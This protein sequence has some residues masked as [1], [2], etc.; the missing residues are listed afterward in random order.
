MQQSPRAVCKQLWRT[1]GLHGLSPSSPLFATAFL[2]FRADYLCLH[3]LFI[4]ALSLSRGLSLFPI[5]SFLYEKDRSL[6]CV[7]RIKVQS[8]RCG[9]AYSTSKS[10]AKNTITVAVAGTRAPRLTSPSP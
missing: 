10:A 8:Q 3:T 7:C 2:S 1:D 9:A 5:H 6:S 4:F